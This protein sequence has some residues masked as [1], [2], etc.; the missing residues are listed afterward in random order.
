MDERILARAAAVGLT[1]AAAVGLVLGW[2]RADR[3]GRATEPFEV[4]TCDCGQPYRVAGKG[5]HRVYWREG[6]PQADPVLGTACV[7]CER[8]LP[9]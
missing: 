1:A 9:V 3:R 7:N 5:R 8:P 6:A 2:R 4:W